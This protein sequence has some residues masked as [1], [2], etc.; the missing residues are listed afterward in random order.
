MLL[1]PHDKNRH[2]T[3][4]RENLDRRCVGA[5][6]QEVSKNKGLTEFRF[7]YDDS[8]APGKMDVNSDINPKF[9]F[10]EYY[11]N[12]FAPVIRWDYMEK[13][14][15]EYNQS[16][17]LKI[18]YIF[19]GLTIIFFNISN[20]EFLSVHWNNPSPDKEPYQPHWHF[21]IKNDDYSLKKLHLPITSWD[22]LAPKNLDQYHCWIDKL[23]QFIDNEFPK[24]LK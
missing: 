24:C 2:L 16:K 21:R 20:D 1:N 7:R 8:L 15:I 4:L 3:W 12:D 9:K 5:R 22:R 13:W 14:K 6:I 17:K 19:C 10:F 18:N 11:G 23:I